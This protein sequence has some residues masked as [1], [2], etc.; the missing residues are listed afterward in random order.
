MQGASHH[1]R[2][3][4]RH[5]PPWT[6]TSGDAVRSKLAALMSTDYCVVV[7]QGVPATGVGA[8]PQACP[9]SR[10]KAAAAVGQ[11][12]RGA[13][14]RGQ[15]VRAA[16]A[17]QHQAPLQQ[18]DVAVVGVPERATPPAPAGE[19]PRSPAT[20]VSSHT[21]CPWRA[22]LARSRSCPPETS[23]PG[24]KTVWRQPR[25]CCRG[26]RLLGTVSRWRSSVTLTS[27]SKASPLKPT[28]PHRAAQRQHPYEQQPALRRQGLWTPPSPAPRPLLLPATAR[29]R[30]TRGAG[31]GA[32]GAAVV[33][34][35]LAE[36]VGQAVE[37][38]VEGVAV[39][40]GAAAGGGVRLP[41]SLLSPV[42]VV[43]VGT[44]AR[45][46]AGRF[47]RGEPAHSSGSLAGPASQ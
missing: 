41:Q 18:A 36:E 26:A 13:R 16:P 9:S 44:G 42:V 28:N 10:A 2:H 45:R 35:L 32:G 11:E 25:C 14:P 4:P 47:E 23:K 31:V 7:P 20:V 22:A 5:P 3:P 12:G 6:A 1:L 46:E 33:T 19:A 29:R 24:G 43:V 21:V 38:A 37:R 17:P 27:A 39:G 30:R 40:T 15:P 34:A 8:G